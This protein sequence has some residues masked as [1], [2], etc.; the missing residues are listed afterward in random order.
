MYYEG[1]PSQRIQQ[2]HK[3]TSQ[4]TPQKILGEVQD[5]DSTSHHDDTC[6][7]CDHHTPHS[8]QLSTLPEILF[9]TAARDL[10]LS[11]QVCT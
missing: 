2:V 5:I 6:D 7:C 3:G 1:S 8:L 4:N 10:Q 9:T 11:L